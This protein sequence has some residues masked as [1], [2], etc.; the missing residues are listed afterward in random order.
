MS[1]TGGTEQGT[2]K[3]LDEPDAIRRKFKTAVTDSGRE[4]RRGPDKPGITNL[5]EI[6]S[7]ASGEPPPE[8]EAQFDGTGYGAFKEAVGEAVV[9]LVAPV[10]ERYRALRGDEEELRR[11][12]AIGAEKARAASAPT[13]TAMYERMGFVRG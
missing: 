13:L 3:L 12:L 4:V 10:Q 7:V 2:V 5:V 1:T 8:I 6:M 11:L 9:A